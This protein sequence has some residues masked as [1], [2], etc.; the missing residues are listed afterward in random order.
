MNINTAPEF[1]L[2]FLCGDDDRAYEELLDILRGENASGRE[3]FFRTP[4]DPRLVGLRTNRAIELGS[5]CKIFRIHVTVTKGAAN[6]RLHALL[7][8]GG[9]FA[10]RNNTSPATRSRPATRVPNTRT[11]KTK[12]RGP[13]DPRF[14]KLEYPFRIIA[15][16]ENENLV[17]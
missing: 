13:L 14:A 5:E 8:A 4:N 9:R 17:D 12:T 16:R 15:L 10:G 2:R 6:F 7:E 3:P 11:A 1:L